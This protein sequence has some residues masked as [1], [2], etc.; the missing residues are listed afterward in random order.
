MTR[1]H[2]RVPRTQKN[3]PGEDGRRGEGQQALMWLSCPMSPV[4]VW[5]GVL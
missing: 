5:P 4:S 1:T 3:L 2:C